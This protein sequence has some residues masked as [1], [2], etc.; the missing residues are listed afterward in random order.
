MMPVRNLYLVPIKSYYK[1]RAKLA[2][3]YSMH[4]LNSYLPE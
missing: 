3:G 1:I 4:R 2:F